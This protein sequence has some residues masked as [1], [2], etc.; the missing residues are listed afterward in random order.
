MKAREPP[1]INERLKANL[2][3]NSKRLVNGIKEQRRE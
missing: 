2:F 3:G 1:I